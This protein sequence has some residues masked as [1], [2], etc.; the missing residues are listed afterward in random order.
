MYKIKIVTGRN[1]DGLLKQTAGGKGISKCGKYQFFIDEDIDDPDFL[2]IRNKYLKSKIRIFLA[3]GNAALAIS[4]P[5]SVVNF[6]KRYRDQFGLVCSCQEEIKHRN[7]VYTPAILPWLVGVVRK[8][9]MIEHT[10]S[11]D[12]LKQTSFPRKTKLISVITSSKAFTR[13]HK[14]RISFVKKLKAHYGD[15]LDVFGRGFNDFDDKWDSLAPYKY[16]IAL[17][18]SSSKYYWTEKI[19][20]C[21]LTGTF[22]VY[23]GCKNIGDYFPEGAFRTI[24]IHNFDEAV[25]IIDAVIGEDEYAKNT[26]QLLKSKELVLEDYNMFNL[27]AKYCDTLNPDLPKQKVTLKP[28]ITL[29]DRH[30]FY[31]YFIERNYWAIKRF[32]ST[33]FREK[34]KKMFQ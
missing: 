20:D 24:N 34:E 9:G 1:S 11:Y 12:E 6:P 23:Y 18:N 19:S 31:L 5:W 28:A 15:K 29:L 13:G 8:D 14:D 21:Y 27:I 26:A 3:P 22:P 25:E 4:E 30:N 16:H 33:V 7:I 17:E 32:L 10:K 2:I